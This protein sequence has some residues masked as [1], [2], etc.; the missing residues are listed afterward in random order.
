VVSQCKFF[1]HVCE[2]LQLNGLQ[3]AGLRA[4]RE[5]LLSLNY[6][7][8]TID[9]VNTVLAN[10]S[11]EHN[12]GAVRI[13]NVASNTRLHALNSTITGN[14][15]LDGGG[16]SIYNDDQSG[17]ALTLT[18][19]I[20]W[21]NTANN[22]HYGGDLYIFNG[23]PIVGTAE[24]SAFYSDVGDIYDPD[25]LFQDLGGNINKDPTLRNP[26]NGDFHLRPGSPV[27]DKGICGTL[28]FPGF[29]YARIAPEV[30]FE[31]DPRPPLIWGCD[32]GAD[33]YVPG[34]LPWLLL[35]LGD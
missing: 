5:L 16:I 7:P 6:S 15:A 8:V 31:G 9:M 3:M 28:A 13:F 29:Q 26:Q 10:N 4:L 30:D 2:R 19:T 11:A 20:L 21:G 34:A 12:G 17:V 22:Y 24:V 32:M 35:L 27:V 33:E 14:T 25:G 18:N 23:N 1:A